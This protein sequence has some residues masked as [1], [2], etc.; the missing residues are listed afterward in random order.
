MPAVRNAAVVV[1]D[2]LVG[3]PELLAFLEPYVAPVAL[4]RGRRLNVPPPRP[5]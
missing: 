1:V 2:A 5:T 3:R 4:Q